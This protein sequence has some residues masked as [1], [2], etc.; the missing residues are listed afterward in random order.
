MEKGNHFFEDKMAELAA[1]LVEKYDME[2]RDATGVIMNSLLTQEL[3]ANSGVNSNVP[4]EE[5]AENY[6]R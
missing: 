3:S 4:V 5:L 6:I 2:P 1:Y